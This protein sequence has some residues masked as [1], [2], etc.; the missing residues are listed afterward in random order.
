MAERRATTDTVE[1]GE[2]TTEASPLPI[3][4]S[5]GD[6]QVDND[7]EDSPYDSTSEHSST[8]ENED[9][10]V[11][12]V[13]LVAQK[14]LDHFQLGFQGCSSQQHDDALRRHNEEVG[15]EHGSLNDVFNDTTFPSVLALRDMI[16]VERLARQHIPSPAQWQSV[17]CGIPP[18]QSQRSPRLQPMYVCLHTEQTQAVTPQVAF[19]VDSFLGFSRSLAFA[20]KGFWYQPAPQMRQNM[21]TDVHLDTP[22][23]QYGD[24]PEQPPRATSALLRDVPHFL[25]GR[26]AGA[27]DI[28]VHVLFPHMGNGQDKFISL[29]HHD[30]SRW[31]DRVF[32]PAVYRYCDAHYSQHLPA[33]FRQ[34]FANSKA[35]QVEGRQVETA[36]YRTQQ[37][38]GY[39]LQPHQL[40]LIW[41]QVLETSETTPG[42]ADFRDPQLFFSAKGTKLCFKSTPHRPTLLDVLEDFESYLSDILDLEHVDLN[43]FFVDVGK[44]ICPGVSLLASHAA[45][46]DE[47]P[48][49]YSWKRCCLQAHVHQLYDGA[50]PAIGARGQRYY[51]QNM[52]REASS[53]TSVPP[54]SSLLYKGGIRYF[55]LYGSVKEV[56]DAAKCMPFANDGLEEMALDPTIRKGARH[57]AAGRSRDPT[58]VEAA[59]CASKRR[60]HYALTDCRQKSFGIRE[61]YRI[62]WSLS[63]AL[64]RRLQWHPREELEISLSDCPSYVWPIQT[65]VYLGFL[66]RSAD[67]FASGFEVVRARCRSDLVTWEQTKMM[68]MF[69]RCL[70]F[71]LGGHQLHRESALWWSRRERDVGDPPRRRVWYGLGFSNTLPRYGYCWIEPRFDWSQLTFQPEV[72]DQVLF[73]NNMLRGQYLRQGRRVQA[74]FDATKDLEL[75]LTWLDRHHAHVRIRDQLVFWVIHLC[76]RQFRMDILGSI[77]SEILEVHRPE[78]LTGLHAF[79]YEYFHEIMDQ[80]VYLTGG[81]RS[82]F[83]TAWHMG[84][85]LFDVNDGRERKHWDSKPFRQLYRRART[86]LRARFG[87]SS[88]VSRAFQRRFWRCLFGYHWILPHPSPYVFLQVTKQKQRMWYSIRTEKPGPV[89]LLDPPSWEWA[90]KDWQLGRPP[91]LPGYLTWTRDEWDHWIYHAQAN[92]ILER[93]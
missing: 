21:T 16:S 35:H 28:T 17:F 15:D 74:F 79:C 52:L 91:T 82:E 19:D 33:S 54:K 39:H 6:A 36:S 76:L 86:A 41:S 58:I 71:V 13:S 29:T 11:D 40:G 87:R 27:H 55:Q 9:D 2:G 80:G 51:D 14:L 38:I 63:Q 12:P 4:R 69:L 7:E 44:E 20:R 70:R 65:A 85:Y 53:V 83:K 24:D 31:F 50:A 47:Q 84:H 81:N 93:D 42:L 75:A 90:R 46:I 61:E 60:A 48:Q 43:R 49:V 3:H 10:E 1:E 88:D 73:G 5:E 68:A 23:Y 57:L 89:H 77:R 34:A 62:S 8:F 78:A 45:G 59:Y 30:Y 64:T 92:D 37:A 22:S 32:H 18:R 26:I 67:K 25:L 72:T 56:W 66:W